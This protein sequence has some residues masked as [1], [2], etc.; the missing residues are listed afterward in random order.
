M[1]ITRALGTALLAASAALL[2][3]AG[4]AAADD[5]G[6]AGDA[7]DTAQSAGA[8]TEAGTGFRTATPLDQGQQGTAMASTGDYLYWAF[9]LAAGQTG[10]A[11]ATVTLPESAARSGPVTWQLDV[12][13][14]LRR[15]Q[16]C[17]A[18]PQTGT[19]PQDADTLTLAC[20]LRTVQPWAGPWSDTPLPGA[21][22]LRLTAVDLPEEDLGLPVDIEVRTTVTGDGRGSRAAG[23]DL[24][25][26]LLPATGA[27]QPLTGDEAAGDTEQPAEADAGL[28]AVTTVAVTEPENGWGGGWWTDRWLWTTAGGVLASAAAVVGYVLVR[29]AG[30]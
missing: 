12:Y 8:P 10:T 30:R 21:Y 18:G 24:A 11:G 2:T 25:A 6:D 17:T 19:A 28:T 26:P 16:P 14:G 3:A 22:Y 4:P 27:G 5:T 1:R 9:P 15:R 20:T 7:G 23:G 29:R 13:D